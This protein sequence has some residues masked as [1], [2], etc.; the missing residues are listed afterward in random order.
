MERL[1]QEM[2]QETVDDFIANL[3][4]MRAAVSKGGSHSEHT[5]GHLI[6]RL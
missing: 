3:P 5:L 6:F 4:R 2:I 1:Q